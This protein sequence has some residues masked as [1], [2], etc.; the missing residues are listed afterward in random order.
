MNMCIYVYICSHMVSMRS[1]TVTSEGK[2]LTVRVKG[3]PDNEDRRGHYW[4]AVYALKRFAKEDVDFFVVPRAFDI[5]HAKTLDLLG[6]LTESGY[7][8]DEETLKRVLPDVNV[9][10]LRKATLNTRR[11]SDR[12]HAR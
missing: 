3:S 2:E 6:Q 9:L 10:E 11:R 4:R 1:Y 12:G 7:I 5:H 8:W